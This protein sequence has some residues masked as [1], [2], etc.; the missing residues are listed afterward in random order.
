MRIDLDWRALK[1]GEP[2]A[3]RIDATPAEAQRVEGAGCTLLLRGEVRDA[4]TGKPLNAAALLDRYRKQGTAFGSGL[5]GTYALAVVDTAAPQLLLVN[6]RMAMLGWCYAEQDGRIRVSD[7]ADTIA[8]GS[9]IAAQAVFTYLFNHVIPSPDTIF[10]GVRRL[11]PA[12]RLLAREG[13]LTVQAHWQPVFVEAT[14]PD[15]GALKEQFRELLQSAALRDAQRLGGAQVGTFLSGGTDSSTVSGMLRQATQAPVHAYSIGFD[16]DGYDEMEYARIAARH[17]GLEHHEYYLTPDDVATGMPLVATHYDQPFGNSSAVAAY[18]CARVAR[19]DG[20]TALLAGDGG[21]E[22]FGGNTRYAKQALFGLYDRVP[23]PVRA[24]MQTLL[25]NRLA[26]SIPGVSKAASYVQQARVPMPDR[27]QMYNL[28][29]RLGLDQVLTPGFMAQVI[30]SHDMQA[31]RAEYAR[32]EGA[33]LVNRMLAFDWKYTLADNDLPKVVGTTA[34]AGMATAFPLLSDEL[35]DFSLQLPA[36][37]KL[38]GQKLR[39]FFKEAL[40]GFLPDQIISK[41]KQGFGLPFGVWALRNPQLLKLADD[42]LASFSTRGVVAPAF[43]KRL[44]TELLPAHP[45]YYGE[46]VWIIAMLEFWLREKR[47]NFSVDT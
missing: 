26:E 25:D 16:A 37:Y 43:M 29:L 33:T 15:F 6:D 32:S 23:A 36:H 19:E 5:H 13:S 12:H 7:R 35:L 24:L 31:Q 38:N 42:A 21:D 1:R 30:P 3:V 14:A 47:P 4:A 44:R 18:H 28:L 45:G 17:F 41:K 22:L 27:L 10:H 20:R 39:W 40:R 9:D 8:D 2:D 11:P 46:L 34:L